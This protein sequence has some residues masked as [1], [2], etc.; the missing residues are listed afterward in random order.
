[1]TKLTLTR[2]DG[3][4]AEMEGN[5][6]IC[7]VSNPTADNMVADVGVAAMGSGSISTMIETI[8]AGSVSLLRNM[9]DESTEA[10]VLHSLLINKIKRMMDGNGNYEVIQEREITPAEGE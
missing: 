8:A 6:V 5:Q 2:D 3:R 9:A 7:F 10:M 1:M 4:T